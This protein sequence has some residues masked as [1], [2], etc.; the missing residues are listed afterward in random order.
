[1]ETT[2]PAELRDP[3][4]D[5]PEVRRVQ[6]RVDAAA[7]KLL[8]RGISP[9]VERIRVEIGGA[10]PNA[11]APALRHW[12]LRRDRA[13]GRTPDVV[14]SS[15]LDAARALYAEALDVASRAAGTSQAVLASQLEAERALNA[16]L[17]AELKHARR[18]LDTLRTE[19][20]S[21]FEAA[22]HTHAELVQAQAL[23]A[24]CVSEQH[25]LQRRLDGANKD[26]GAVRAELAAVKAALEHTRSAPSRVRDTARARTSRRKGSAETRRPPGSSKRAATRK[27][28]KAR[29]GQRK[30]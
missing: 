8:A 9:T 10:S 26:L 15:V 20:A 12:R 24:H 4:F 18:E 27:K 28:S 29:P 30:R 3:A 14:P 13:L 5:L 11:V 21:L 23:A 1:M 6:P 19:R 22:G 25:T 7:E 2:L 16:T 17:A